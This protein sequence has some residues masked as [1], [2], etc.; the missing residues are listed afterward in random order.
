MS[1]NLSKEKETRKSAKI[2]QLNNFQSSSDNNNIRQM[3]S[4]IVHLYPTQ[5]A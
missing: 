1:N 4:S 5:R 3:R 2:V